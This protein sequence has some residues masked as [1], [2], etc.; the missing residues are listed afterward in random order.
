MITTKQSDPSLEYVKDELDLLELYLFRLYQHFKKLKADDNFELS[1]LLISDNEM[2]TIFNTIE[3]DYKKNRYYAESNFSNLDNSLV[4]NIAKLQNIIDEK[5][6]KNIEE[7]K[8]LSLE[9]LRTKFQLSEFEM[10]ILII[11]LAPEIAT[12]FEKIYGYLQDDVTKKKPTID[13]CLKILCNEFDDRIYKREYFI[14]SD[15]Y[16]FGILEFADDQ[17]NMISRPIKIN[18]DMINFILKIDYRENLLKK[19]ILIGDIDNTQLIENPIDSTNLRK[20]LWL[21]Y[22]QKKNPANL[23]KENVTIIL[24]DHEIDRLVAEFD[25]NIEQI[26]NS[27]KNSVKNISNSLNDETNN[28]ISFNELYKAC[29]DESNESKNK[30]N[31]T[32][33]IEIY[34]DEVQKLS[35]FLESCT[36]E[37]KKTGL[38]ETIF[39]NL[40]GN[41]ILGKKYIYEF[42]SNKILRKIK[43]SFLNV[44]FNGIRDLGLL[45]EIAITIC[46]EKIL[47]NA[48]TAA[49]WTA[50]PIFIHLAQ[51][52]IDCSAARP[53]SRPIAMRHPSRC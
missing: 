50:A 25:F 26:K 40:R 10:K 2:D 22:L 9:D 37:K 16:K 42:L 49:I 46:R 53:L 30:E 13:L 15:L 19:N 3:G 21:Y 23:F 39:I 11:S 35:H 20:S 51:R 41:D 31:K 44:D 43:R 7:N 1:G 36:D 27:I 14:K 33:R 52:S 18:D 47:K 24:F 38:K 29:I 12:R 6:T 5:N 28:K 48:P 17:Q 8:Y 34:K 45:Q 32:D 4:E